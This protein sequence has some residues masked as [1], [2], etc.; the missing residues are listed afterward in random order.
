MKRNFKYRKSFILLFFSMIFMC[1]S[2]VTLVNA[3]S[4]KTYNEYKK[5]IIDKIP[6]YLEK[7]R[8]PGIAIAFIHEGAIDEVYSFG[9]ADKKTKVHINSNTIFQ[10][11]SISK[12]FTAWGI[13][14]LVDSGKISL[15]DP[16]EK[17]LKSWK[18]PESEYD[19]DKI[20]IRS[21]LTHTSGINA[22]NY[23]GYKPGTKLPTVAESLNSNGKLEIKNEPGEK[24]LYSGAGYEILEVLI[25]DVTGQTFSEYMEEEILKPLGMNN[26]YFEYKPEFN[27]IMAKPHD[28]FGKQ[29]PAYIY[30]EKAAAGLY[31]NVTDLSKFVLAG[32]KGNNGELP[33]RGVI[34]Q[35]D[36]EMMYEP[37]KSHY[38]FGCSIY[39][40]TDGN[41]AV[42]HGGDNRGWNSGYMTIP[43]KSEGIV[44]LTNSEEGNSVILNVID[45]WTTWNTG[46]RQVFYKKVFYQRDLMRN[47]AIGLSLVLIA[48]LIILVRSFIKQKRNFISKNNNKKLCNIIKVIVALLLTVGW[49]VTFYTGTFFGGFVPAPRLTWGFDYISIAVELWGFVLLV[50]AL[51]P[52]KKRI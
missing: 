52:K 51:F 48:Y 19:K 15:D 8:T 23:A 45:S 4:G 11:A 14:K 3:E 50:S 1:Q 17:Y 46:E 5:D 47:V 49:F 7:Y 6:E 21:L 22:I 27:D 30:A 36:I 10:A 16:V 35:E 31:T 2:I 34:K 43:N 26:S 41:I 40:L 44:L 20:T 12:S 29:M 18:L 42:S 38:G 32:I 33:G 9:Y 28:V 13:L 24:F 37:F 25:E 39:E